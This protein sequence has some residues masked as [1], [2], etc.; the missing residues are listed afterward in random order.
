MMDGQEYLK[1]LDDALDID[2]G[3]IIALDSWV[4]EEYSE[5]EEMQYL[6]KNYPHIYQDFKAREE[7]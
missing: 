4:D 3:K 6:K 5:D 2:H 1:E 7:T